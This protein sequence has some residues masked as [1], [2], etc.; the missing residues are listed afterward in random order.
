[1]PFSL[2]SVF[3]GRRAEDGGTARGSGSKGDTESTRCEEPSEHEKGKASATSHPPSTRDVDDEKKPKPYRRDTG[4][5]QPPLRSALAGSR[6]RAESK[7]R[8]QLPLPATAAAQRPK[9]N[10]KRR[11]EEQDVVLDLIHNMQ[12]GAERPVAEGRNRAG[13]KQAEASG[14]GGSAA[15]RKSA[16]IEGG[17]LRVRWAKFKQ[18]L[19]TGS[20]LSESLLDGT[21][22]GS[23][24]DCSPFG[25]T[26]AHGH[27]GDNGELKDDDEFDEVVVDNALGAASTSQRS[28]R[29]TNSASGAKEIRTKSYTTYSESATARTYSVWDIVPPLGFLRWRVYPLLHHFFAIRFHD[30]TETEF[31]KETWYTSKTLGLYSSL[32][33]FINWGL[34]LGLAPRPYVNSDRILYYGVQPLLVLPLPFAVIYDFPRKRPLFYQLYIS[35]TTWT[36]AFYTTAYMYACDF[37]MVRTGTNHCGS[38][39]FITFFL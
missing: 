39:D 31:Q 2:G 18:R 30:G 34:I 37:Y 23:T 11:R 36:L 12:H 3:G 8:E 15:G 28:E 5:P 1:M 10:L 21:G 20:T 24:T 26:G 7:D 38:R 19:G 14:N 17:G 35:T 16:R 9:S 4:V 13:N 33:Y 6:S 22:N 25:A 27:E 29:N 32:F